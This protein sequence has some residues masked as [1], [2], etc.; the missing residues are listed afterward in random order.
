[1]QEFRG[2]CGWGEGAQ[3]VGKGWGGSPWHARNKHNTPG[4]H[5]MTFNASMMAVKI[6]SSRL[7][8][9]YDPCITVILSK[10]IKTFYCHMI[11]QL[12]LP[13]INFH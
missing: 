10:H 12:D 11:F 9:G 13:K 3:E 6:M 2:W 5:V 8:R 4:C 7:T 1:M